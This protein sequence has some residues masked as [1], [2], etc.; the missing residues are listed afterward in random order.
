MVFQRILK[1]RKMKYSIVLTSKP[2]FNEEFMRK[3]DMILT[4]VINH[5]EM[6]EILETMSEEELKKFMDYYHEDY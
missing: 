3:E 6:R 4:L 5:M 2:T 1:K